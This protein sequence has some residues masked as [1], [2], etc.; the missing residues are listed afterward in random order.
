MNYRVKFTGITSYKSIRMAETTLLALTRVFLAP[1]LKVE[2]NDFP[3]V[4]KNVI[5]L[6]LR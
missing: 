3:L 2:A 5:T 6:F 1:L 4:N